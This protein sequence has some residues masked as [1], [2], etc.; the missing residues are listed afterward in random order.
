MGQRVHTNVKVG[1]VDAHCLFTHSTL[2]GITRRLVVI[3]KRNDGS[4]NTQDHGGMNFAVGV[5][6]AVR[7]YILKL[8][9]NNTIILKCSEF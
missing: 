1:N 7:I 3:R 2:I 5:G 6:G 9:F 8:N 4:A